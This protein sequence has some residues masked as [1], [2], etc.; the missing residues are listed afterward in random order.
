MSLANTRIEAQ[1][2]NNQ[3]AARAQPQLDA[4]EFEV[5]NGSRVAQVTAMFNNTV[6]DVQHLGQTQDRR[7]SAPAWLAIGGVVALAGAALFGMEAAQDWDAHS[8]RSDRRGGGRQARA[9][10]AGQRP[11]RPRL[12]PGDARPGPDRLRL[13]PHA[14]QAPA[15]LVHPR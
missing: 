8:E 6:I 10:Q 12:R 9:G 7:K 13:R 3:P 11:R 5:Q 15:A 1:I 4:R 2:A 14:G